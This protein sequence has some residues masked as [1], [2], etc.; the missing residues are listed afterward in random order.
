MFDKLS[1]ALQ[2]LTAVA[3]RYRNASNKD[4]SRFTDQ[5]LAL[6]NKWDKK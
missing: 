6:C 5:I 1:A 2:R 3:G 4:I